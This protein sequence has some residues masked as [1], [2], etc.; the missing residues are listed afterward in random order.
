MA[1]SSKGSAFEREVCKMLSRWWTGDER[2]DV[3]WRSAGSGG[4]AKNR[5]N[6]GGTAFGQ[7]GDIQATDPIGQPL[8]DVC[9]IE[10]KRGYAQANIQNLLDKPANAKAQQL[11]TFLAQAANDSKLA[12]SPYW[13]L[14]VRRSQKQALVMF[15]KSFLAQLKEAGVNQAIRRDTYFQFVFKAH[16]SSQLAAKDRWVCGTLLDNFLH[17]VKR[18]HIETIASCIKPKS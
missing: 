14:I 4:M 8:I 12:G 15:N 10:L 1:K 9:S 6:R 3:F 18:N 17:H 11:E 5:S 16:K 13:M 7:Y 2:D